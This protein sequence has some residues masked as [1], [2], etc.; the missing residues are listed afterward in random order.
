MLIE[1][2]CKLLLNHYYM[3]ELIVF[4]LTSNFQITLRL[5]GGMLQLVSV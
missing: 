3:L 2:Q 5:A 1:R 4:T